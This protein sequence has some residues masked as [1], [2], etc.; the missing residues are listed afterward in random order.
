[1][2][3]TTTCSRCGDPFQWER[4]YASRNAVRRRC[5][6]RCC[7]EGRVRDLGLPGAPSGRPARFTRIRADGTRVK[8]LLD[9]GSESVE[10][11]SSGPEIMEAGRVRCGC[12]LCSQPYS[13]CTCH[14]NTNKGDPE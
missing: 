13:Q 12:P 7:R 3:V 14:P 4:P 8:V 6:R 10:H 1:M 5:G 11:L 2:T 9:P